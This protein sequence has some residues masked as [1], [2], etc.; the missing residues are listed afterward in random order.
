MGG[1]TFYI[2]FL[3]RN[4]TFMGWLKVE[5]EREEAA[6]MRVNFNILSDGGKKISCETEVFP[7]DMS[8]EAIIDSG[9]CLLLGERE[10]QRF[11]GVGEIHIGIHLTI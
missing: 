9:D 7:I 5:A 3:H 2:Q 11:L 6:M 8:N 1:Q 10:M 4:K